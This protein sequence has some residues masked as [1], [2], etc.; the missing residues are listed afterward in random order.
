ML[1]FGTA[2]FIDL[3]PRSIIP[4][5][6]LIPAAN[7]NVT[8]LIPPIPFDL[9]PNLHHLLPPLIPPPYPTA[10]LPIHRRKANVRSQP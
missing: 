8:L 5:M 7:P 6:H 4:A 9:L 3:I 1:C 10:N 2:V